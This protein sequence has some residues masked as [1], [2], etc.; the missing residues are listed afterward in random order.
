MIEIY[1]SG[2]GYGDWCA[3]LNSNLLNTRNFSLLYNYVLI[4]EDTILYV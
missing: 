4:Y 1:F 3:R 2:T